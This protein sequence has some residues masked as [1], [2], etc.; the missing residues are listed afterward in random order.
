MDLNTGNLNTKIFYI[1]QNFAMNKNTIAKIGVVL[2]NTKAITNKTYVD[3]S[4]TTLNNIISIHSDNSAIHLNSTEYTLLSGITITNAELNNA[5]G[6]TSGVQAQINTKANKAGD[7]LTGL[8]TL[9]SDPQSST[10]LATKNYADTTIPTSTMVFKTGDLI[11]YTN[12][13]SLNGF[14]KCNGA[15]ISKTTYSNLYSV[16][17]DKYRVTSD[18]TL[19]NLPNFTSY[20]PSSNLSYY[21]KT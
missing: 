11:L 14:L 21:I 3:S 15:A 7:T 10:D 17:G 19:F 20:S 2:N 9:Y 5:S 13:L 6:I 1:A 18:P 16:I 8:L 4:I 12:K